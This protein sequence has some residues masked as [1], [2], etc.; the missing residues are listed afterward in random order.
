MS[1]EIRLAKAGVN[2]KT[3]TNPNDFIFH[4][5]Y[6]TFKIVATGTLSQVVN[7]TTTNIEL[8]HGLSYIP[9]AHG[10]MKADTND[11]AVSARYMFLQTGDYYNVS[12]NTI[13]ADSSKVYFNVSQFNAFNV[14]IKIRYYLFEVPL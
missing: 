11:E 9:L 3:A 1:K 13:R 7:F 14:T 4:S 10:F 5:A 12:L 8:T 6:N 2:V